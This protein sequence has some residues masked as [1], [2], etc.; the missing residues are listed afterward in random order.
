MDLVS[1]ISKNLVLF[2]QL[3]DM[4]LENE[5]VVD[6]AGEV[7]RQLR[8]K[9]GP[10]LADCLTRLDMP[11]FLQLLDIEA[12]ANRVGIDASLA[13]EAVRRIAPA[14]Q[15]FNGDPGSVI[16]KLAGSLFSSR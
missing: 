6:V 9:E 3:K 10:D 2:E 8:A 5:Q 1:L 4:G 14:V 11:G 16:G 15:A 13:G 12:I 7:N